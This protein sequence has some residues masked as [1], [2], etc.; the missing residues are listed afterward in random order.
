[1][2]IVGVDEREK[3]DLD[4]WYRSAGKLKPPE[5]K[6][7]GAPEGNKNRLKHGIFADRILNAE[8]KVMFDALIEQLCD[9][10]VFNK[11]SDFIQVELI[12]VYSV[13]LVR[14]QM[15]GDADTAEKLDRM[16]RCHM[17]DLKTTKIAREGEEPQAPTTSPAEWAAAL[18]EKVS[19]KKTAGKTTA[20]RKKAK[21]ISDNTEPAP[22]ESGDSVDEKADGNE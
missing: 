3:Q 21:K 9:D 14:A 12:G 7:R 11:S 10:F 16:I 6:G 13:K 8:E 17:K 1:M 19:D 2:T 5:K 22:D 15:A 20:S 18:L 4:R